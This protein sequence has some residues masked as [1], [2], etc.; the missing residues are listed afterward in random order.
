LRT[1]ISEDC[2][3]LPL[4]AELLRLSCK[5]VHGLAQGGDIP[6]FKGGSSW[7]LGK[8]TLFSGRPTK[9]RAGPIRGE[10][11]TAKPVAEEDVANGDA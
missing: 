8:W 2:L 11:S 1:R 10:G 3:T 9:L 6:A 5:T 7:P 4:L